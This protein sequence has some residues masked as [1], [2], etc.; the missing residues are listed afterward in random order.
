MTPSANR[1]IIQTIFKSVY[2]VF[3]APKP[4]LQ[5]KTWLPGAF[6]KVAQFEV[7]KAGT[8][9]LRSFLHL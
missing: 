3:K 4:Y 7:F 9:Y 2:I 1:V 6:T 8:A 5:Y